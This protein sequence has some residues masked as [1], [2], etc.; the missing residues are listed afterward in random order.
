VATRDAFP[1][2]CKICEGVFAAS[3]ADGAEIRL[4]VDDVPRSFPDADLWN[5]KWTSFARQ[6]DGT[7]WL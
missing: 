1:E 3:I 5:I 6:I 7:T 4:T 2:A